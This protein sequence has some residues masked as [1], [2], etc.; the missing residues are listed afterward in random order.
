MDQ[1]VCVICKIQVRKEASW[2]NHLISKSHKENVE[3]AKKSRLEAVNPVKV[4]QT[5]SSHK[6]P[7]MFQ[8]PHEPKKV[9]GI[10]KN[11]TSPLLNPKTN[12][13]TDF[14]DNPKPVVNNASVPMNNQ[15]TTNGNL[16]LKKEEKNENIKENASLPPEGFFDDPREDA[17]VICFFCE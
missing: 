16:D 2:N 8:L 14:Y 5:V 4:V 10:L 7:A 15:T 11:S 13:P 12:L 6:R 9:K 1:L 17:K 3:L